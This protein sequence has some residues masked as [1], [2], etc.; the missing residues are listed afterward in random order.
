[1]SVKLEF[2]E[3]GL[4]PRC[5]A[6][7]EYSYSL[8]GPEGDDGIRVYVTSECSVC[9]FR[10]SKNLL[11]PLSPMYSIRHL[12]QPTVKIFIEKVRLTSELKRMEGA[13]VVGG[14]R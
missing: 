10:E 2:R 9:G 5:S 14:T 3:V 4:C 7:I 13:R 8:S 1:M 6:P 12:F 11:F